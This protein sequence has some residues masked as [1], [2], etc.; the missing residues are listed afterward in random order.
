[1]E[2]AGFPG[3]AIP[4]LRST[5]A[6]SSPSPRGP[7]SSPDSEPD[8]SDAKKNRGPEAKSGAPRP[9][10][11]RPLGKM[12]R[13][14]EKPNFMNIFF[15]GSLQYTPEHCK[16]WFS[17]CWWKKPCFKWL[18]NASFKE[19]CFQGALFASFRGKMIDPLAVKDSIEQVKQP[20]RVN[21]EPCLQRAFS[22]SHVQS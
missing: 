14:Q 4:R 18:Q 21:N 12:N 5:P 22:L 11:G 15:Q 17:L 8:S 6:R 9:F 16:W 19:L 20:G 13:T 7:R 2:V 10:F 3:L 1:M